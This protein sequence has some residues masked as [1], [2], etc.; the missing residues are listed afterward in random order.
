[1]FVD[2]ELAPIHGKWIFI[3]WALNSSTSDENAGIS[4]T[5]KSSYVPF[6][7]ETEPSPASVFKVS[8]FSTLC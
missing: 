7:N 4:R 6:S 2:D 3:T 5:P 8:L 1:M